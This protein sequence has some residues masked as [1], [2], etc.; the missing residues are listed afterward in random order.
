VDVRKEKQSQY[1]HVRT[2]R[3]LHGASFAQALAS[4]SSRVCFHASSLDLKPATRPSE[5]VRKLA[6][7]LLEANVLCPVCQHLT[8]IVVHRCFAQAGQRG[9]P[10]P[11]PFQ[12][13]LAEPGKA[14]FDHPEWIYEPKWDGI[15]NLAFA[16]SGRVHLWS[17]NLQNYTGLFAAVADTL[18]SLL[19]YRSH[20][21]GVLRRVREPP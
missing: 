16:Q 18:Q 21:G 10:L 12:P 7:H 8:V 5:V 19:K 20:L 11:K 17:R 3:T 4:G 14:A 6:G 1:M 13:M 15:R 9:S 2:E